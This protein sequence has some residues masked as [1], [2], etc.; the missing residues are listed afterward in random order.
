MV[1]AHLYLFVGC[2]RSKHQY[3]TVPQNR[4]LLHW[5]LVCEWTV[6]LLLT[7]GMLSLR[8]CVRRKVMQP[9]LPPAHGNPQRDQNQKKKDQMPT[10]NVDLLC[11]DHVPVNAHS[12]HGEA[13]LDTCE[14]NETVVKMFFKGRSPTMR[15]VSR[16]HRVALDWLLDRINLDPE[17]QIK[18]VDTK[19]QLEDMLTKDSFTRDKWN[20]L[21]HLFNI[22][23]FWT[24]S[25]SHSFLS[26]V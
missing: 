1:V 23:I 10:K 22:M 4:K 17:I 3:H 12:S 19:K 2:A 6:Y 25:R 13:Q 7:C 5:I 21:L 26:K 8:Y 15:H 18:Y 14:D 16:T 20:N 24:S 9:Q 11:V